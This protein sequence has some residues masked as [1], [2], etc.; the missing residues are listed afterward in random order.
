[1]LIEDTNKTFPSRKNTIPALES[2]YGY[3]VVTSSL[4]HQ[5]TTACIANVRALIPANSMNLVAGVQH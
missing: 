4:T 5:P 1:M 3:S 2:T